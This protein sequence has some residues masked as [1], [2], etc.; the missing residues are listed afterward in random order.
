MSGEMV[1]NKCGKV[2]AA[3]PALFEQVESGDLVVQYF[4]C[5]E[6][7]EKY[8]VITTDTEMRELIEKRKSI[9]QSINT[10]RT[11]K[12]RQKTIQQYI[13]ELDRIIN[14]QKML[15]PELKRRGEEILRGKP[16]AE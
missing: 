4:S 6:C 9:Q 12:F 1:C 7:G 8:Q 16:G 3:D 13:K 11:K 10:A 15:L 2:F 5:P 14:Q